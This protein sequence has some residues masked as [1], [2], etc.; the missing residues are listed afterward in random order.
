MEQAIIC[1]CCSIV[2]LAMQINDFCCGNVGSVKLQIVRRGRTFALIRELLRKEEVV[3]RRR[4]DSPCV[5][6]NRVLFA[7][8]ECEVGSRWDRGEKSYGFL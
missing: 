8:K 6:E 5:A 4:S 7:I 3:D 2:L 1:C